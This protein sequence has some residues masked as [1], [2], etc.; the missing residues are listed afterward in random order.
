MENATCKAKFLVSSFWFL[1]QTTKD[2]YIASPLVGSGAARPERTLS[3]SKGKSKDAGR[4]QPCFDSA[5][6][7]TLSMNGGRAKCTNVVWF[8]LGSGFSPPALRL[9]NPR[10]WTLDSRLFAYRPPLYVPRSTSHVPR[11]TFHV[12]RS[13]SHASRFTFP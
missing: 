1:N 7:A 13:T 3:L 5:L 10:R 8:D 6:R 11:L 2:S 12:S 4:T 9:P